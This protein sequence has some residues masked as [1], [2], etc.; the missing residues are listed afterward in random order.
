MVFVYLQQSS[1]LWL[2][3]INKLLATLWLPKHRKSHKLEGMSINLQTKWNFEQ[4]FSVPIKN[5]Q[6]T[7]NRNPALKESK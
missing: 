1:V 7:Q 2:D 5:L 3:A 4:M 6:N